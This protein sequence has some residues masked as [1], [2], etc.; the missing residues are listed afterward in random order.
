[1]R[2]F[3]RRAF[4]VAAVAGFAAGCG[5]SSSV[6]GSTYEASGGGVKIEFQSGGKAIT[7]LGPMSTPCTYTQTGKTI[8]LACANDKM[9]LTVNEDGSLS[10]PP[11][12]FAPRLTKKKA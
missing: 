2:S 5:K 11:Q 4:L 3:W 9:E 1:M 6:E 10:G 12:G 8:S 7:T